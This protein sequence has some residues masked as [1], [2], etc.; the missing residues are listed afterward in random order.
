VDN[1]VTPMVTGLG[2]SNGHA[3]SPDDST[4]LLIDSDAQKLDA[5]DFDAATGEIDRQRRLI[6]VDES[7]GSPDGMT[8]DAEGFLWVAMSGGVAVRRYTPGGVLDRVIALPVRQPT[9]PTFGG[10]GLDELYVTSA[11]GGPI[12]LCLGF[13]S[14][15][16]GYAMD[17][18]LPVRGSSAFNL[19]PEIKC[20]AV[21]SGPVL[22]S[23]ALLSDRRGPLVR[24][25]DGNGGWRV[26]HD[27]LHPYDSML[28]EFVD[29][30]RAPELVALRER[31]R[32]WRFY[33]HLRTDADAPARG[34]AS[35]RGRRCWATTAW[36][37]RPRCRRSPRSVTRRRWRGPSAARSGGAASRSPSG[38]RG[39]SSR[40]ISPGCC[41]RS[42]SRSR[43]GEPGQT[44]LPSMVA[45]GAGV[46]SSRLSRSQPGPPWPCPPNELRS[47]IEGRASRSMARAAVATDPSTVA[48]TITLS[49]K[50]RSTASPDHSSTSDSAVSVY[51][52]L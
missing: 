18:G 37:S 8:L 52:R 39:S 25:R 31:I 43:R 36:T 46:A 5:F 20:E 34:C 17:L 19:D 10:A 15:D 40:C 50:A 38:Q 6:T 2:T 3:W 48:T 1:T 12:R 51:V 45:V 44:E 42:P 28:S 27:G 32:G 30:V 22:R 29:V 33:D 26:S 14:D 23:S 16:L 9:C 47:G 49:P 24:T 21:W 4:M 41:A 7:D 11:R 13:V 35:A